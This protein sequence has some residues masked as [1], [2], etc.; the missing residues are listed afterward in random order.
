LL[1][2]RQ[3][4]GEFFREQFFHRSLGIHH[5]TKNVRQHVGLRKPHFLWIDSRAC[6]HGGD[7][8]LLIFAVH[9]RET[10]GVTERAPMAP[11]H[12]I[13]DGMKGAAPNPGCVD[14]Q[15]I[16]NTIEHLPRGFVGKGKQQ[17]VARVHPVLEQIG[18]AIGQGARF[19]RSRARNHQQRTRWRRHRRQLLLIQF[20]RVINRTA[21]G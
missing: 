5:E 21:K 1:E 18:D 8:I 15:Q 10:R 11:Q 2:Q 16:R 7:Q 6:H 13:A 9:N 14:R 20:R 17:N 3:E 19:S 4:I 12:P